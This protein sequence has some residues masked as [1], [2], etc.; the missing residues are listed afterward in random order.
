MKQI[1]FGKGI[2]VFILFFGAA[3]TEAWRTQKWLIAGLWMLVGIVFLFADN[4]NKTKKNKP[5]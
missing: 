2:A 1:R 5:H 4:I 3:V